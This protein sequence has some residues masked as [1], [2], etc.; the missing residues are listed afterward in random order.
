[1]DP[2][3]EQDLARRSN[4]RAYG[5]RDRKSGHGMDVRTFWQVIGSSFGSF[6]AN[7][8]VAILMVCGLFVVA[9]LAPQEAQDWERVQRLFPMDARAYKATRPQ[10]L[11]LVTGTLEGNPTLTPGGL[12]AYVERVWDATDGGIDGHPGPLAAATEGLWPSLTL[13]VGGERLQTAEVTSPKWSG[14]LHLESPP[15]ASSAAAGRAAGGS[16][17][18]MGLKNGD[19]ITVIGLKGL[20]SR[21]IPQRIY[22]GDRAALLVE[23][24]RDVWLAYLTGIAFILAGLIVLFVNIKAHAVHRNANGTPC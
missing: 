6:A 1:M 14:D 5:L 20:D 9:L 23:L 17:Q 13:T 18:W 11:V 7:G 19:Q 16:V 3:T 10:S 8:M 4:L 12:V 21:L 22:R 2:A 15:L 24:G